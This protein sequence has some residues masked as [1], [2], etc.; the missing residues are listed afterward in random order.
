VYAITPTATFFRKLLVR[1]H[2]RAVTR[3][4]APPDAIHHYKQVHTPHLNC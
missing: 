4:I 1:T 3:E 2:T